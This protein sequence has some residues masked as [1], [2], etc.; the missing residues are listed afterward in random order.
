[1][2]KSVKKRVGKYGKSKSVQKS[3][4]LVHLTLSEVYSADVSSHLLADFHLGDFSSCNSKGI[5]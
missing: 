2:K 5:K 3:T 4:K 1:M